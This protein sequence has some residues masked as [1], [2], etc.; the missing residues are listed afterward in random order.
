MQKFPDSAHEWEV[1]LSS[2]PY[3]P[4]R[5]ILHGKM[6]LLEVV[7]ATHHFGDAA[8]LITGSLFKYVA[9]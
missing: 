4:P 9:Q 7:G 2:V 6:A 3:L 8:P 5:V 1:S